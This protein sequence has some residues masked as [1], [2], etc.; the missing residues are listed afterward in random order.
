M[1]FIEYISQITFIKFI[2]IIAPLDCTL[3]KNDV[4]L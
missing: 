2:I 3:Y 1:L 4:L